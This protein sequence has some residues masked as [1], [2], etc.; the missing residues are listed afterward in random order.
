MSKGRREGFH[1]VTPYIMV[2]DADNFIAFLKEVFDATE[3]YRDTGSA[4]GTHVELQL[5][6]SM[7]MVGGAAQGEQATGAFYLYLPD[8]DTVYYKALA[9]GAISLNE[10]ANHHYGDRNAGVKDPFGNIWY[11]GSYLGEQ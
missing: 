6:D 5:G 3:T 9:A 2:K 1:T 10:P 8:V 11:I 4:G 7:L